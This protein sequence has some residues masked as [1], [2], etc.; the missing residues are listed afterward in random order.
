[1]IMDE[2]TK[3]RTMGA[4]EITDGE[5]NRI[6]RILSTLDLRYPSFYDLYNHLIVARRLITD[7]V[8]QIQ[9]DTQT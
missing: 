1:V 6:I 9:Q 3:Q 7:L 2:V 5:L 4:L 8:N